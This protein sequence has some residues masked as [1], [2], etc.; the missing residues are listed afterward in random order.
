MIRVLSCSL[1][2]NVLLLCDRQFV[3]ILRCLY[4][5]YIATV[6]VVCPAAHLPH[7]CCSALI[8]FSS[9]GVEHQHWHP[10]NG[11]KDSS[12]SLN[13]DPTSVMVSTT[14][15]ATNAEATNPGGWR[16]TRVLRELFCGKG[17]WKKKAHMQPTA[18][19]CQCILSRGCIPNH[20]P[21]GRLCIESWTGS[22]C[23]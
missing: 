17:A 12:P 7:R 19:P 21:A 22:A 10:A 15:A 11:G 13:P 23:C 1:N 6:V 14:P 20:H 4:Q 16:P 8:L 3:G 18:R 9:V 2:M 5:K